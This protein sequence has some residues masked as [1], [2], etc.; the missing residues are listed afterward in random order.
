MADRSDA[1]RVGV[2][3]RVAAPKPTMSIA[4]MVDALTSTVSRILQYPV[5]TTCSIPASSRIKSALPRQIAAL[6]TPTHRS[7]LA[8]DRCDSLAAALFLG[9]SWLADRREDAAIALRINRAVHHLALV[10]R[11]ELHALLAALVAS[12]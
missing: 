2:K 10:W 3:R 7:S 4:T 9:A 1:R 8:I 5:G 12:G 11:L 6:P